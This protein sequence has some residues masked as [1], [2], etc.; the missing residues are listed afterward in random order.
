M[1]FF[2][3]TLPGAFIV[4]VQRLVDERGFF[5]RTWCQQEFE[6]HGLPSRMEQVSTSYNREK[7]TL[8]G[9]HFSSAPCKEG[10]LV[11]CTAGGIY[12]VIVDLRPESPAFLGHF[13]IEL[14]ADLRNALYVP[15]G[16]AHGYQTLEPDT[17]ILYMMTESY[18]PGHADGFRWNDPVFAIQ[19]PDDERLIHDRD[20]NYADFDESRIQ[21]FRGYYNVIT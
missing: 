20:A 5:A 9:M 12:D 15:P 4:E 2:E 3:T 19:W 14:T 8:R 17:E 16:F 18:K 10:K 1:E 11:R 13:G 21:G 7:G 6:Q